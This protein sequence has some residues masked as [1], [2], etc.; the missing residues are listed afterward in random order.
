M[1][2]LEKLQKKWAIWESSCQLPIVVNY[3]IQTKKK[4]I[5]LL[6]G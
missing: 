1:G 2:R 3:P 5:V 4:K 6:G